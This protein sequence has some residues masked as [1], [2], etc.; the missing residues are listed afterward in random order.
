MSI[1]SIF[2]MQGFDTADGQ[3]NIDIECLFAEIDNNS[4][5][6]YALSNAYNGL[7]NLEVVAVGMDP[8]EQN[9]LILN[10]AVEALVNPIYLYLNAPGLE[11][12][13]GSLDAS[14]QYTM[15]GVG[16]F[17]KTVAKGIWMVLKKIL[18]LTLSMLQLAAKMVAGL[19]NGLAATTKK[20]GSLLGFAMEDIGVSQSDLIRIKFSIELGPNYHYLLGADGRGNPEA[21]LRALHAS[22]Q[23]VR[24]SNALHDIDTLLNGYKHF[25]DSMDLKSLK[26]I[27]HDVEN[28]FNTHVKPFKAHENYF[29]SITGHLGYK[30]DS[31]GIDMHATDKPAAT[32]EPIHHSNNYMEVVMQTSGAKTGLEQVSYRY[33]QTETVKPK[34]K[35]TIDFIS[36]GEVYALGKQAQEL[37]KDMD[38]IQHAAKQWEGNLMRYIKMFNVASSE[39]AAAAVN[40]LVT[41]IPSVVV[42]PTNAIQHWIR[43]IK[44]T[45]GVVEELERQVIGEIEKVE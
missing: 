14:K 39:E 4:N 15:E 28:N 40:K 6:L 21:R 7:S 34:P 37:L 10:T 30:V 33:I 17:L 26:S 43:D 22:V 32:A 27:S 38:N 24:I 13:S 5:K 1:Y 25:I 29:K 41:H 20:L 18:D 31:H 35:T 23:Q 45:I 9:V 11:A 44:N 42:F 16:D 36:T 19:A 3:S 8:T 2:D 12:F